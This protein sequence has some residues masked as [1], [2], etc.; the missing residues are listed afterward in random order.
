[1]ADR[2]WKRHERQAAGLI[3]GRRHPANTGGRVDAE[4]PWAVAQ[5]KHVRRLSLAELEALAVEAERQGTARQKA[6]LVVVKRRAG[7]G[8]PTPTLVAMTAA[9]F[10]AWAGHP[11][12]VDTPCGNSSD[13]QARSTHGAR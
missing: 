1:V 9:T 10:R 2:P 7:R 4:S 12:P 13:D 6:G 5:C 8:Q 3:G 11:T